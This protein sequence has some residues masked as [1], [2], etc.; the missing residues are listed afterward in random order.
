MR[1]AL[2]R[3]LL[4][5]DIWRLRAINDTRLLFSKFRA[6]TYTSRGKRPSLALRLLRA[7]AR[8]IILDICYTLSSVTLSY[9]STYLMKA[10]LEAIA[11]ASMEDEEKDKSGRNVRDVG[12]WTP[13]EHAFVF[14]LASVL[15]QV[16]MYVLKLLNFHH[17]RQVGLRV[18]SVMVAELFQKTLKRR[19]L[20]SATT[21]PVKTETDGPKGLRA[22]LAKSF[23]HEKKSR[24]HTEQ[25]SSTH[26]PTG[27]SSEAGR[28]DAA[29]SSA[30][31]DVGKVVNMMS[32]DVNTLLRLG[33]DFHQLS[34]VP[35]DIIVA[36]L[37]LYSL[38][39]WAALAGF[40]L[41]LLSFPLNYLA[42]KAS[43]AVQRHWKARTD[44]RM[45]LVTEL[46]GAARFV[47]LQGVT[48]SW[49]DRVLAARNAEIRA[50]YWVRYTQ[51][52]FAIV[53]TV[54]PIGVSLLSFY[55]Y[56]KI[57][58][59]ELSVPVAFT[60]LTLFN[61]V[62][63][64]LNTIPTFAMAILKA[65]V[66]VK[67]LESFLSEE[68]VD[69]FISS[70]T[71]DSLT[72]TLDGTDDD[73]RSSNDSLV[74]QTSLE[75]IVIN[76]GTFSWSS[77]HSEMASPTSTRGILRD[78]AVSFPPGMLSVIAGPTGSGK[79]TL[80]HAILGELRQVSGT[81]KL[82]KWRD[83]SQK[84]ASGL[85]Y[86]AQ[87]PWLEG[88]KSIKQNILF[89]HPYDKKRYESVIFSCALLDDIALFEA[90]DETR[91]SSTTLSGG[92]QARISLARAMYAPS[93]TIL[94]DDP[95]AAVDAHVQQHLVKHALAGATAQGRRV[96]LVTHHFS[97][98]SHITDYVVYLGNGRVVFQGAMDDLRRSGKLT[99][100]LSEGTGSAT[101]SDRD[102]EFEAGAASSSVSSPRTPPH[103]RHA[104]SD[105]AS[106][107][108][109]SPTKQS[110]GTTAERPAR[111]LYEL[112]K[113]RVGAVKW[114]IYLTYVRACSPLLWTGILILTLSMRA[115]SMGQQ[116]WLKIWGEAGGESGAR[117]GIIGSF[118]PAQGHENFYLF[119]YASIGIAMVFIG[120]TR[121]IIFWYATL[122]A[123]QKIY[124]KLLSSVLA[125]KL[126]FF[127]TNPIGRLLQRFNQDINVIDNS[128]PGSFLGIIQL[129]PAILFNLALCGFIVP[130]FLLPAIAFLV[131]F[132]RYFR[133]FLAATQ[134]MQRI[135]STS[136]SPLYT[137]F[138]ASMAG[139][140][141]IRAFGAELYR[142]DEMLTILDV[143][144]AQ[145]WAICTIEVWGSFRCQLTSGL[146]VFLVTCLS[147]GGTVSAGSAGIVMS[148]AE[149]MAVMTYYLIENW[150]RLSNDFNSIERVSEYIDLP[151]EKAS[152]NT[153]TGKVPPAA[154]PSSSGSI[155]IDGVTVAYDEDLPD[156]LHNISI[157]IGRCEKVGIVGRTGS[158]K[159]TLASALFRA[160]ELKRGR[161]VIDGIDIATLDVDE[162][163]RRICIVPQSPVLFS[164]TIRS[165]L[166]P[167]DERTDE[168]C[169][170]ALRRVRIRAH[171][172]A[173]ES[174]QV[175]DSETAEGDT[176]ELEAVM[177]TTLD[178][179]VTAGGA[180]FSAGEA[181]LLSLARALLRDARV[182]VLDEATS[183]TDGEVDSAIQ[184]AVREMNDCIVITVAHRLAT[185]L[186]YDKI[187]VL[188]QGK[189]VEFGSPKDLLQK[190]GGE[191]R[192][193]VDV[194]G[195][196]SHEGVSK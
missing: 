188:N 158:G 59:N 109:D 38:L 39:G 193:M 178:A 31:A 4:P 11:Q 65:L 74:Q 173:Q 141:T 36:T 24:S 9:G 42:G 85:S 47:K 192:R 142:M 183:S 52:A 111:L 108:Q 76:G 1:L 25:Q 144:Q 172:T 167:F 33:C 8:D 129:G 89:C 86:A 16:L 40:S 78:V 60:A 80:L 189:V 106:T 164:G 137:S 84:S 15:I 37:F 191:F 181:Q 149:T 105:P 21:A 128:L 63:E 13:R 118:P 177:T 155:H 100:P 154:W 130:W 134:D 71:A 148:S 94:L 150:K 184:R 62:A 82:P 61:N 145:W 170:W 156:V 41:L 28:E 116:Y 93:H 77:D 195:I 122:Q 196:K 10:I 95:L 81:L 98:V 132:P 135:E 131:W 153:R 50:L 55:C 29:A 66:S 151:P 113:R 180:N 23:G 139:I 69:D 54:L 27:Q 121:T 103:D 165:N 43:V 67:R 7:N 83:G 125:A 166:D 96:L 119:G 136:T 48:S 88:G 44:V 163:R 114:S 14:A 53:F 104:G 133:G 127:D 18:R 101:T 186:D 97:A 75:P 169:L 72:R 171:S 152:L 117:T 56:V 3:P 138:S 168:E 20:A 157:D 176:D 175:S 49:H 102:E 22:K 162:L 64:P 57:R 161:I 30:A 179:K 34:K 107:G 146:A 140:T 87:M 194:M 17:A 70:L 12:P 99:G 112:E 190:E 124:V 90:G 120:V 68:E 159:T 6:S 174:L 5:A 115:V 58:G 92:Q 32:A 45:S 147:L 187:L 26:P 123:S 185:V 19:D 143:T 126:R 35:V 73:E 2:R 91:I 51:M 79:S 110:Q 182:V 46:L 160:M